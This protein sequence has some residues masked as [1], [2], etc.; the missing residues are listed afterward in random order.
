[1][2]RDG[3]VSEVYRQVDCPLGAALRL[4]QEE[5]ARESQR[6]AIQAGTMEGEQM[7][8]IP[9]HRKVGNHPGHAGEEADESSDIGVFDLKRMGA[10]VLDHETGIAQSL[11]PVPQIAD[12]WI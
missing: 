3:V 5:R 8:A 9:V 2:A 10:G 1:M 11:D 4:D 6:L 12:F 7:V